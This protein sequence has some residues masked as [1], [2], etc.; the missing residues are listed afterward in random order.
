VKVKIPEFL[1]EMSQ[2]MQSEHI[3]MMEHPI[4][5]VCYDDKIPTKEDFC[6]GYRI[7]TREGRVLFDSQSCADQFRFIDDAVDN[8]GA[9]VRS[10]NK[11][12]NEGDSEYSFSFK[13]DFDI[14][15][16]FEDSCFDDD[17]IYKKYYYTKVRTVVKSCLT[18]QE[19]VAYI[20]RR[21]HDHWPLYTYVYS[22]DYC[23]QMIELR[24]WIKG[25]AK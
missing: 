1:V 11:E 9:L 10:Y 12:K 21:Q 5:Q 19:A 25:L 15:Y 3:R 17:D 20:K 23:P 13:D 2:Q 18:E 24:N 4:W 7:F 8:F 16:N 14:D 22:M 6:D